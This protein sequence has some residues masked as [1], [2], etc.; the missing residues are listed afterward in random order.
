MVQYTIWSKPH[1]ALCTVLTFIF[2]VRTHQQSFEMWNFR[3]FETIFFL[4]YSFGTLS[5]MYHGTFLHGI[6]QYFDF[7]EATIWVLI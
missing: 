5:K 1:Q 6:Y 4:N 3:K 2:Q 7:R